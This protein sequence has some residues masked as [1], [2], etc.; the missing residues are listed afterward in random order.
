MIRN[1]QVWI[2]WENQFHRGR[3]VDFQQNLRIY[4][5]LY[6]QACLLGVLPP[7]NPLEGIEDKIRLA[8]AINVSGNTGIDRS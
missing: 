2:E 6:Q 3:A 7:E 5:A 8:K 4:E 1:R